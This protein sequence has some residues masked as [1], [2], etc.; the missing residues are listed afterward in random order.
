MGRRQK[1]KTTRNEKIIQIAI[2]LE[3]GQ[4]FERIRRQLGVGKDRISEVKRIIGSNNLTSGNLS[5][6]TNEELD[7]LF[8]IPGN[9]KSKE[10]E[11]IYDEPDLEYYSKELLKPG[12]T[13]Q[14]LWEEYRDDCN[15]RNTI[16]YQLTQFKVK[17]NAYIEKRPYAQLILHKPGCL[18]EVDW[19]GD[20]A[21]WQDPDTGEEVY[22]WLFVGV[23]SFSGLTYAEVFPDMMEGN[24]IKAHTNMFQYFGGVTPTLRCDNLKTGVISHSKD[25]MYVLQKDYK[26]LAA[27]YNIV[28]VPG[29]PKTPRA[30]PYAENSV[31]N[32]EQRL[33]AALRNETCYSIEEYNRKLAEKLEIFN[34]KKFQQREGSR[35]S[36]FE[37]YEKETLYPLPEKEYEYCEQLIAKLRSDGFICFEKNF[38][39]VPK[40]RTGDSVS[41]YAYFDR[42]EIY[43]GLEQ[44]AVHK[45]AMKGCWKKVY[46]PSHFSNTGYGEWSKDRFLR[47]AGQIG[48]NTYAV[49]NGMFASGPEQVYYSKAHSLLK[50]S[51]KYP[52]NRLENACALAL[53]HVQRPSYRTVKSILYNDQDLKESVNKY[54]ETKSQRKEYAYLGD[55]Y[56][57]SRQN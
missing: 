41:V 9:T 54:P 46:D 38:Y 35:R 7:Q 32:C 33:L 29:A 34:N 25:G 49:V 40:K 43:D 22:G 50:L 42:I 30:K 24:W 36:V 56:E 3:R 23:L 12:V 14:L 39:S 52:R 16:P 44:L 27:Y 5:E 45:R 28:I 26:G 10:R 57:Q 17:L 21:H 1:P 20:K 31:K 53:R 8:G 19:T 2:L 51:D 4:S 6:M 37:E 11:S 48:P 47:W 15:L 13:R 18:I 55:E